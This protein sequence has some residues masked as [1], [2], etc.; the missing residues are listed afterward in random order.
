MRVDPVPYHP[1][2]TTC[3]TPVYGTPQLMPGTTS[4]GQERPWGSL[5]A[6]P[7]DRLLEHVTWAITEG[8]LAR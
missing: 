6:A 1:G 8:H 4:A 3:T 7:G 2:Y 5:L